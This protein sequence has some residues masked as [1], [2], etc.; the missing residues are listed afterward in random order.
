MHSAM[1]Q[2]EFLC[3]S[4]DLSVLCLRRYETQKS[5]YRFALQSQREKIKTATKLAFIKYNDADIRK[6]TALYP[7]QENFQLSSDRLL[8]VSSVQPTDIFSSTSIH[9]FGY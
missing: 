6:I 3:A 9:N 4:E 8:R 7:L 1:T 2:A 5:L